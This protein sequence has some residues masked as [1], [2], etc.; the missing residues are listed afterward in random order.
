MQINNTVA[1]SAHKTV[2]FGGADFIQRVASGF[3]YTLAKKT[4]ELYVAIA[5]KV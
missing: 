5:V 1:A 3:D 4:F 2:T